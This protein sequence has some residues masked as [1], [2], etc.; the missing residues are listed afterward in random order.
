ML[1]T[2]IILCYNPVCSTILHQQKPL[3]NFAGFFK[4]IESRDEY[5]LT[6]FNNKIGAFC[7]ALIVFTIFGF[8]VDG[9]AKLKVLACSFEITY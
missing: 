9:K 4:G 3:T 7:N 6:V 1:I 2:D 8:L 5:F